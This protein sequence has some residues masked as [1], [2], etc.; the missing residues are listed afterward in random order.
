MPRENL[1]ADMT[2]AT[3][4]NAHYKQGLIAKEL[5]IIKGL[6]TTWSTQLQLMTGSSTT[7]GKMFD[8]WERMDVYRYLASTPKYGPK[9]D[10]LRL[11]RILYLW[12]RDDQ[13]ER[14]TTVFHCE[15]HLAKNSLSGPTW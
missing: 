13:W 1:T 15:D 2:G 8:A 4:I 10:A 9:V 7:F 14:G 3:E 12:T 6:E 5:S 11:H